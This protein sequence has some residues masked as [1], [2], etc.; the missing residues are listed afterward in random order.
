MQMVV[1]LNNFQAGNQLLD[2]Q[3]GTTLKYSAIHYYQ[4]ND[5]LK[6]CLTFSIFKLYG[7]RTFWYLQQNQEIQT[8]K[9]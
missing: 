4:D 7:I 5:L 6:Y 1:L 8:Q 9:E 2:G 3:D